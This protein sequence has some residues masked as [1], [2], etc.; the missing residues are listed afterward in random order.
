[1]TNV[2][3]KVSKQE[4][5]DDEDDVRYNMTWKNSAC[6]ENHHYVIQGKFSMTRNFTS[7]IYPKNPGTT[8]FVNWRYSHYLPILKSLSYS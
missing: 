2:F 8:F 7:H 3:S 6:S 5:E 1:M 4:S